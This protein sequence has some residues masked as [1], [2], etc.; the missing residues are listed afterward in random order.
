MRVAGIQE[1][2]ETE[3]FLHVKSNCNHAD[4]LTRGIIPND[5]DD[6]VSGRSFLKLPESESAS[7]L[8]QDMRNPIIL[9]KDNQ[10]V[11]LLLRHLHQK[12][13]HCGY[14]SLMHEARRKFWVVGLRKMANNIVSKCVFYRNLR[15]KP[16]D[17]LMGQ[18]PSIRVAA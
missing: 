16:L 3:N 17:Q 13:G 9:P 14:R 6:W 8:P 2:V 15:K 4:A 18:L 11:V 10:L 1:T 7:A 5:L 12:R